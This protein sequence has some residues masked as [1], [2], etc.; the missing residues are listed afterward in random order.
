MLVFSGAM[1]PVGGNTLGVKDL[2]NRYAENGLESITLKFY[3]GA[4][5]EMLNETNRDEV[6]QDVLDWL[7]AHL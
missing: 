1:D 4:R 7:E 5:H 2:V 3:E 6:H